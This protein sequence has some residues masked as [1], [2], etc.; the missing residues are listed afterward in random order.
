MRVHVRQ[1]A[2]QPEDQSF[3]LPSIRLPNESSTLIHNRKARSYRPGTACGL[4]Y[5]ARQNKNYPHFRD[6]KTAVV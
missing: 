4:R 6:F 3:H 2:Y 5:A 1:H